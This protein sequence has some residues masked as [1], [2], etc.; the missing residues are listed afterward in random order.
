MKRLFIIL[1]LLAS[2]T[3]AISALA[4]D[5][6]DSLSWLE[7]HWATEAFGGQIEEVWFPAAGNAMHGVFRLTI[8]G[9]LEFSEFIQLTV[10]DGNIV[11]RFYHFRADYTTWEDGGE[12]MTLQVT[13]M[14]SGSV[15]FEATNETSPSLIKYTLVGGELQVTVTGIEEPL[16]FRKR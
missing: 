2:S 3:S 9:K 12:P 11:M 14:T 6:L 8:E 4:A 13:E 15:A 5:K 16:R 7:G 10:E 1:T